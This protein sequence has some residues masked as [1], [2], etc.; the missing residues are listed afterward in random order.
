MRFGSGLVA[1]TDGNVY[2]VT[3][4]IFL[5]RLFIARMSS[6]VSFFRGTRT[7]GALPS[8][9]ECVKHRK[10]GVIT[11]IENG[12]HRRETRGRRCIW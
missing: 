11:A 2:A 9:P 4:V 12:R 8:S 1:R 6:D 5:L 7:L 10:L 3:I